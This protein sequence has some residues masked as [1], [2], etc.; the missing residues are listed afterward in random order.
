MHEDAT[1]RTARTLPFTPEQIYA[2]FSSPALLARWWGPQGFSNTFE[3]FDFTVGGRWTFVMHGPDGND[4]ANEC[5]FLALEPGVRI[6][7]E[8]TCAPHFVLTVSLE[9]VGQGTQL[10]WEQRFDDART[11]QVIQQR[12]GSA[13]EQNLDRL[14][15]VLAQHL[16]VD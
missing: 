14:T 12:I 3:T 6:V 7:I 13:N 2:A 5:Q 11:A 9:R 10:R 4:Y 1:L 15:Q 16:G 8:H